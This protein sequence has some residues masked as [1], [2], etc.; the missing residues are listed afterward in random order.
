MWAPNTTINDLHLHRKPRSEDI[1]EVKD[2]QVRSFSCH[3]VIVREISVRARV[4][5]MDKVSLRENKV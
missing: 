5:K 2:E 4:F 3:S 1:R